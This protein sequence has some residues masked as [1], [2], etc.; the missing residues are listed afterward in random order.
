MNLLI[1]YFYDAF[2]QALERVTGLPLGYSLSD[3]YITKQK[4]IFE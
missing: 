4:K 3:G 2:W 1:R